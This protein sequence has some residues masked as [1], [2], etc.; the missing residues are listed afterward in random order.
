[1]PTISFQVVSDGNV[2]SK[3][4]TDPNFVKTYKA[5]VLQEITEGALETIR[6]F[7]AGLW[8][9]PSG[10]GLDQSWYSRVDVERGVG[11]ISNSKPYSYWLDRGVRPHRQTYL[12]N[13]QNAW[14]VGGKKMAVIPIKTDSG[15]TIFRVATS[16]HMRRPA[17]VGPWWHR[18]I[19]PNRFAEGG[20]LAEGMRRYV[21]TRLRRD[22]QGLLIRVLGLP[23]K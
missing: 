19:D 2:L 1:M 23:G 11:S 4:M 3:L 22:F 8:K 21:D 20:F 14:T 16:E 10:G 12:L 18:G 7:A 13:S 5:Y 6:T 9:N 17:G 15:E